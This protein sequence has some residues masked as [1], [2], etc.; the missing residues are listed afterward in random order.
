VEKGKRMSPWRN[1]LHAA[2]M[3]D[4][5]IQ[6]SMAVDDVGLRD[7]V[8]SPDSL[9]LGIS[10]CRRCQSNIGMNCLTDA[11]CELFSRLEWR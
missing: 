1:E 6:G 11:A 2:P 4:I 3:L 8:G 9:Q 10:L 7:G 5:D